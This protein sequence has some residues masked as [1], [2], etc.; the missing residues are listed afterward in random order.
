MYQPSQSEQRRR[1]WRVRFSVSPNQV[2]FLFRDN[3]LEKR[4]E[5]GVY[6]YFD[7]KRT[8]KTVVLPTT[9]KIQVISNQEVL[10]K[11]NVALRFSYVIEYRVADPETF[12][13]N[14][15]VFTFAYNIF[16]EADQL[17]HNLSQVRLR[18]TISEIESEE[19][20]EK[21]SDILPEVPTAL[22]QELAVY[23]L[24]IIRMLI[25]DLTFPKVIQDLFAKQLE[26]KIR[27]KADLENARTQVAA[28]RALKNASELMKDDDN[29]KFVQF[30]ETITKIADKGKHTFVIGDI[31]RNGV[32]S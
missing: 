15:D 21:R 2:G 5:P 32:I 11:D 10:T 3:R 19:L 1:F 8:L 29:I 7:Y 22:Q 18:Q 16:F 14:F 31:S 23:G 26:S 4:L 6:D 20:N 27:A 25:R 28:A 24:E 13:K 9:S 12:I 17:V 30:M